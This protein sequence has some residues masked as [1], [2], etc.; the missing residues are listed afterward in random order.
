MHQLLFLTC[1]DTGIV[2]D[3]VLPPSTSRSSINRRHKGQKERRGG[4]KS[5]SG[6]TCQ[7]IVTQP[8]E[9]GCD[10]GGAE[11]GASETGSRE[12]LSLEA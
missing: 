5:G 8:C 6:G 9:E 11:S 12:S 4:G 2:F 3:H 1:R 7:K 10:L